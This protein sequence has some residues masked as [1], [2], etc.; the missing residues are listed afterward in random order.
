[1]CIFH[2]VSSEE[3]PV[4]DYWCQAEVEGE[5]VVLRVDMLLLVIHFF[6]HIRLS[7]HVEAAILALGP[8]QNPAH[9]TAEAEL[10]PTLQ[11]NKQT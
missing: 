4:A 9:M 1:M 7:S 11:S 5:E 8:H 10:E 3:I 6:L 2:T